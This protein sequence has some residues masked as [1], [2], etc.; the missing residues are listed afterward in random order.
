[1]FI[2]NKPEIGFLAMGVLAPAGAVIGYNLGATR[3]TGPSFG[4]RFSPP[5]VAFGQSG[6]SPRFAHT[7]VDCRLVTMRF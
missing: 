7:V 2:P 1:L 3:E 4:A 5:A 6:D